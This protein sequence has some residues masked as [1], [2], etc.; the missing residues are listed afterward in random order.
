MKAPFRNRIA[1]AAFSAA[2][3]TLI[4]ALVAGAMFVAV[5]VAEA[6]SAS[7]SYR[8][9]DYEATATKDGDL[10]V[11]QRLDY[12]LRARDDG[13]GN[14]KPWKQ[15]YWRYTLDPSN[16]IDITDI[17]VRNADTG[18]AFTQTEFRNPNQVGDT[19]WDSDYANRWYI[20]DVTGGDANPQPYEPGS[21]L[22]PNTQPGK[23][24]IEIGWNIPA[25]KRTNSLKIDVSFTMRGVATKYDDVTTFQWEPIA[26]ENEVP[27]G[28]VTGVVRFPGGAGSSAASGSSDSSGSSS[29]SD[30]AVPHTWLHTANTNE[31]TRD[32]DGT[33]RFT[34]YD[35]KVGGYINVIGA[36]D[37]AL[38]GDVARTGTGERLRSL[39]DEEDAKARYAADLKRDKARF[40]AALWIAGVVLTIVFAIWGLLAVRST[41][42]AARYKGNIEYWRDRPG[43]SP[44]SAARLIDV[45]DAVDS[46]TIL[47]VSGTLN[48]RSIAA[49]VMSLAVKKAI[50]LYPG[51][52]DLYRGID[53]RRPD[54][55]A[56]AR[57]IGKDRGRV[58]ATRSTTTIVI[59]PAALAGAGSSRREALGLSQSES[60]CLDLLIC[61]SERVGGP[62]FDFVQMKEACKDWKAGYKELDR[63][64]TAARNEFALLG[65]ARPSEWR[66]TLPGSLA[67]VL[68]IASLLYNLF[69]VG[70]IAAAV[71]FGLPPVA[72]GL[73]CSLAGAPSIPT[74]IGQEY[75]GRCLGLRRYMVDFSDFT[76]R[77]VPDLVLWDWY[78]VYAAAFGISREAIDQLAKAYPQVRD[79]EWLD[80]NGSGSLWYWTYRPYGWYGYSSSFGSSAGAGVAGS[81]SYGSSPGDFAFGGDS[82]AAGFSDLGT[83]LSAGFADISSTIAAASPSSDSSS[84]GGGFD[85]GGGGSGGGTSGGR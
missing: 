33:M 17:R 23:R 32:P 4:F 66:Y 69:G 64:R 84:S 70:N 39:S 37:S 35:L 40:T 67:I 22:A 65:A 20:V 21:N 54:P 53:M 48:D 45:F 79:P 1:R 12:K 2:V 71:C 76:D 9:I 51:S 63:F 85:G 81:G 31:V 6:T 49:T 50:A 43:I 5:S 34:I 3:G 62:V 30:P 46:G 8:S 58:N 36:F 44:D 74:P 61:I 38:A 27:A 42:R 59:L 68:G 7:L 13:D 18:Q 26:K 82:F 73:F 72:I 77:G 78:M 60:A 15:L 24:T 11:S 83:Q 29:A 47:P 25:T 57:M 28:K 14:D 19:S 75:G 80:E 16:L 10:K 55:A 56:L 52:A 41:N